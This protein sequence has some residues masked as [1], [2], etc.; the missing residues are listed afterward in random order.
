MKICHLTSVHER[1]DIR[2]FLKQCRSL[3]RDGHDVTL[4]VADG[5]GPETRD[6]VRIIDAGKR[7]SSR[8]IRMTRTT[9][10]VFE[11][12]RSTASDI[13]HLHDP[14][15]IPFG[16]RLKREG[17]KVVFDSHE[18]YIK[19]ILTKP[20]LK[21]GSARAVST[22][23]G[24]LE[25]RALASFD[26]VVSAYDAIAVSYRDR[27]IASRVINNYP[28]EEEIVAE[29]NAS[30][31][32]GL[33]CYTGA[34]TEIRGVPKLVD[35]MA[36]C[37]A[38]VKLLL[39]G[40]FTERHAQMMCKASPG[41]ERVEAFGR[42]DRTAMREEMAR[43]IAGVVTFLPVAHHVTAQPNKLF[44]Y[45]AAG[46]AVIGANFPLWRQIIE[47]EG[48]GIC[49]DPADPKAIAAAIDALNA[50]PER[51]RRMGEAGNRAVVERYNW[52]AE[53]EK[54]ASFYDELAHST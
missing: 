20:Y 32:P 36:L 12:A 28:I 34:V 40:P 26:G 11:A 30:I 52:N 42:L 21:F 41:W 44:E 47:G 9:R 3:A 24:W 25:K 6:G 16:L 17:A 27:G 43:C 53:A 23:F 8:P 13:Y 35:A 14:E 48:C 37:K 46:L 18:D 7:A 4:I 39:V 29:T 5:R 54:L 45:M 50:D 31:E 19:D 33:V 1:Y 10:R 51:A 2:I 15:L 22:A 49:V 38:P